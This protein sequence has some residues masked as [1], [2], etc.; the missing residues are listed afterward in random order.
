M[1][2]ELELKYVY[3]SVAVI[4]VYVMFLIYC[5]VILL[6]LVLL[7]N[8]YCLAIQYRKENSTALFQS[9]SETSVGYD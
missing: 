2:Y 1:I 5:R 7:I 8:G 6:K 9:L 3:E 4:V